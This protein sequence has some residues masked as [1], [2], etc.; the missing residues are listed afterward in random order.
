[1]ATPTIETL[2]TALN[3]AYEKAV[4]GLPGAESAEE[5]ANDYA[6]RGGTPEEQAKALIRWQVAKAGTSGFLFGLPGLTALPLT[7]P[8]NLGSVL[9]VQLRMIAAIA[10]LG[11][12]DVRSDQ[13]KTLAYACIAGDAVF[14]PLKNGGIH[15]A[16]LLGK[17]AVKKVPG[18]VLAQINKAIGIKL[19]TKLGTKAPINLWKL[20]PVI[21]GVVG[22]AFD[23]STTVLAGNLAIKL[24][25]NAPTTTVDVIETEMVA[26]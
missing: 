16:M 23:A 15:I 11:G 20:V 26:S 6:R 8:A 9:Y 13:V 19:L 5:L 14:N 21:G 10:H 4:D 3:W 17:N 7:V 12:H 18:S 1:M 25:L 24:F 2:M 22:G